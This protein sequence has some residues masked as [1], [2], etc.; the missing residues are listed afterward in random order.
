MYLIGKVTYSQIHSIFPREAAL[1]KII[2][3]KRFK[4]YNKALEYCK[5]LRVGG[6]YT[7]VP[8]EIDL[9]DYKVKGNRKGKKTS[10]KNL[11]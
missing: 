11:P 4:D 2:S 1:V 5:T 9:K 8:V 10:T 7:F 3:N 6:D